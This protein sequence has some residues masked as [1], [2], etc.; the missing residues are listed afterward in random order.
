MFIMKKFQWIWL[1]NIEIKK[2]YEQ[3]MTKLPERL[4]I[5]FFLFCIHINYIRCVLNNKIIILNITYKYYYKKKKKK[6]V[7]R[8]FLFDIRTYIHIYLFIG[9]FY[10]I[11]LQRW[12]NYTIYMN[13][14]DMC[15][16]E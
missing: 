2:I 13:I 4:R 15:L 6:L 14:F 9:H 5:F 12:N 7:E 8:Y 11:N 16:Y 3:M 1:L 10:F